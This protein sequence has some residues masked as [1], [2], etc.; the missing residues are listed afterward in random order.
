MVVQIVY[1]CNFWLNV[2]PLSD[3][4]SQNLSPRELLTGQVIDYYKH[5][6][7]E[8]GTYAQVHEDHD[9]TMYTRT[10][11]TIAIRPTNNPQGS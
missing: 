6:Q 3:G 8:Y 1:S 7:I 2:F 11:G 9:N 5:C 10:T 4:V